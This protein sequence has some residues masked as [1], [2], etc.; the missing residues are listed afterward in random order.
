MALRDRIVRRVVAAVAVGGLLAVGQAG[1]ASATG[2]RGDDH[3]HDGYHSDHRYS[4][5]VKTTTDLKIYDRYACAYVWSYKGKPSGTV[6][7]TLY[8]KYSD[9]ETVYL[10]YGKACVGLSYLHPGSYKLS[11]RYNGYGSYLPSW[12]WEYFQVRGSGYYDHDRD[13]YDQHD[14]YYR[15]DDGHKYD[16]HDS[17]YKHDDEYDHHHDGY[18]NEDGRTYEHR[19]SSDDAKK[20]CEEYAKYGEDKV[21]DWC[22][23]DWEK[24]YD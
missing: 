9:T 12:D 16:H 18:K 2:S 13:K 8:G 3:D 1:A 24:S 15:H 11:A 14:S 4:S 6:T 17:Y 5:S 23:R 19:Y 21:P 7:F 22:K 10:R 20:K